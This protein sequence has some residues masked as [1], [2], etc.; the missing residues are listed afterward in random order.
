MSFKSTHHT[1]LFP[2]D[3]GSRTPEAAIVVFRGNPTLH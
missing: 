1:N 2:V 3:G